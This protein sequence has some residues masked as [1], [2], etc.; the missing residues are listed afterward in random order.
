MSFFPSRTTFLKIGPVSIQWYAILILVGAFLAYYFAKKNLKEYKNIEVYDFFDSIFIYMLW[1][2]VIGSRLWY[3]LFDSTTNYLKNPLQIIRIWDG[4]LAFHGAFV[5]GLLVAIWYCKRRNV[6]IVKFCDAVCPTLL[7]AQGIGRWGNF[8]NQECFGQT[9]DESYYNGIL[10]FLKSSMYIDGAYREPMF[11]YESLLCILGFIIINFLLR[12][13]QNKRGDLCWAYLMW[14][15]LI[16]FFIEARRTD[17]LLM[18]ISGLKTAQVT[19]IFFL[20]IGLLGF[21]GVLDKL[22]KKKKPTIL[23]DFDGT[24]ADTEEPIQL[25]FRELYKR[26]DDEKNFTDEIATE[27]LGPGLME[28]FVKLFPNEDPNALFKEYKEINN[29][30]LPKMLKPMPKAIDTL[31]T[32]KEEGYNIGIV[33]TRTH[34]SVKHC[35]DLINMNDCIDDVVGIDDVKKSK[36]DIEPFEKIINKNKWNKDDIVMIGD[37]MA[38]INGGKNYGAFTIAYLFNKNKTA[39][40]LECNPNKAVD[41]LSQLLDILKEKRYFTYNNK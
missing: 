41:D 27:V 26:H 40:V 36:P 7:L 1:G 31:K 34:D 32:L 33:T 39:K 18:N 29:E 14:Y 22:F 37:S 20:L 28:M 2:G 11:F 3:C 4:G 10:S 23:F 25:S 16:R 9:V 30:L 21:I 35:M 17:S 24:L 13:N 6:S 38:D 8:I 19:S 15:G 12:K 5:G